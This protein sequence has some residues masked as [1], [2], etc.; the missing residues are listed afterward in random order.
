[1]HQKVL[2]QVELELK[3]RAALAK[4][5]LQYEKLNQLTMEVLM[6]VR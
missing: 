6:G 4:H 5:S 3:N 2:R 1:M